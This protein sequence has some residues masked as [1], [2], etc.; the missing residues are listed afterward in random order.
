MLKTIGIRELK[1]H[2]SRVLHDVAA[3]DV[4][5]VT[6][7][8]N[9][10]AELRKPDGDAWKMTREERGLAALAAEGRLRVAEQAP[11]AYP[12]STIRVPDGTAQWLIDQE[13]GE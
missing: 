3:G 11:R 6:D 10:V 8:H 9:V 13:R 7:R 5:L 2:L 4:Y 1:A 12:A